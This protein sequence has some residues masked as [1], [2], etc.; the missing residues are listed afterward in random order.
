MYRSLVK[1]SAKGKACAVCR[2]RSACRTQPHPHSCCD[3]VAGPS[4]G[5]PSTSAVFS[6]ESC[7]RVDCE[8]C[9]VIAHAPVN[10]SVH[11]PHVAVR[12]P[13]CRR[14]VKASQ[15]KSGPV[16]SSRGE[17][18]VKPSQA[19]GPCCVSRLAT[20]QLACMAYACTHACSIGRLATLPRPSLVPRVH[21]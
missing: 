8:M 18:R 1:R 10:E 7:R 20:L 17:W 16:K 21:A 4:H 3:A 12:L 13:R 19:G 9:A 14:G 11:A 6:M 2:R 15:V 5:R